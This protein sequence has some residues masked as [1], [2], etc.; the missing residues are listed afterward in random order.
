M[1]TKGGSGCCKHV[2]ATSRLET[3]CRCIPF[4]RLSWQQPCRA[5][6]LVDE[7]AAVKHGGPGKQGAWA[8]QLLPLWLRRVNR[9]TNA[10]QTLTRLALVPQADSGSLALRKAS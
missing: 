2:R 6:T 5:G 3:L 1:G 8:L 4:P 10:C 9:V 7:G